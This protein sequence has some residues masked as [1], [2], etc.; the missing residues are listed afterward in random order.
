MREGHAALAGRHERR[1]GLAL[2]FARDEREPHALLRRYGPPGSEKSMPA[3]LNESACDA[4][5]TTRPNKVK[6]FIRQ[7]APQLLTA[8]PVEKRADKVPKGWLE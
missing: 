7:Y 6:E 4:W 5:L 2:L 8:N 3:I 1:S